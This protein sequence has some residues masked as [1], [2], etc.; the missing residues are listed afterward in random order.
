MVRKTKAEAEAT[1]LQI[2]DAARAVF[3]EFG[4]SRTSLEKVAQV[5]GVTRGAIYWHFS[6]KAALFYAVREQIFDELDPVDAL[7]V[8]PEFANPLDAI[9]ASMRAFI[10]VLAEKAVVRQT[11]EIMSL[12]CEYVDEFAEVLI[13]VN[14]PCQDFL[15]KLRGVY[16]RAAAEGYLRDGLDAEAM[17]YDTVT[18]TTGLFQNWLAAAPAD[19]LRG[20]ARA[21]I[22]NHI[23]LRRRG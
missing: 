22:R 7:L 13:E 6:N 17:A 18:F 19:E 5:A 2:I 4:V 1:R 10:D 3:H 16:A 23:A 20:R 15:A 21:L 9:E 8:S 12:R 11:F 14:K